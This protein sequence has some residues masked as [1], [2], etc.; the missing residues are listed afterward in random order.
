MISDQTRLEMWGTI[1]GCHAL[2]VVALEFS[3][4]VPRLLHLAL[5]TSAGASWSVFTLVTLVFFTRVL[6]QRAK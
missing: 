4:N 3:L 5:L 1:A 6:S 2:A